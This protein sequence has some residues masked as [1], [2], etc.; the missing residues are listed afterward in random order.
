MKTLMLFGASGFLGRGVTEVLLKKNYDKIYLYSSRPLSHDKEFA[1]N[2]LTGDLSI[3]ENVKKVFNE[4]EIS[5]DD[6][7]YLF[8]SVGGFYGGKFIGETPY[9]E[10]EKMFKLNVDIAF[11]LGKYFQLK[12]KD[13][14]RGSI[15]FTSALSSFIPEKGKSAYVVSKNALNF[16]V[17]VLSEE[18][19]EQNY[20]ANAIAPFVL[21]S[22]A[23]REWADSSTH[24]VSP[25]EIG[26]LVNSVFDNSKILTGNILKVY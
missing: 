17:Q 20:S 7:L 12:V 14:G 18:G 8:S 1:E 13:C 26:E 3:E 23:N 21:D 11:L 25:Q 16:L 6:E 10:W 19:L 24:L 2:I 15:C 5:V 22:P 4:I 9:E